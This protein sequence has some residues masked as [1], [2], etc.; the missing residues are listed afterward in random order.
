LAAQTVILAKAEN[1][2]AEALSA[3]APDLIQAEVAVAAAKERR[4]DK[5]DD[6]MPDGDLEAVVKFVHKKGSIRGW[7]SSD[8]KAKRV[9]L[10]ASLVSVWTERVACDTPPC[11]P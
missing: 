11:P 10:L 6:T 3:A 8:T 9:A 4:V 1:D 2:V 7:G 5:S